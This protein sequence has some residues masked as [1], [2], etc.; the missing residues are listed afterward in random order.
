MK[1]DGRLAPFNM[2][3]HIRYVGSEKHMLPA[4][5]GD[6]TEVVLVSRMVGVVILSPG[7][8]SN[9]GGAAPAPWHCLVQFENGFQLKITTKNR[10]DFEMAGHERLATM[11]AARDY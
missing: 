4:G 7:A 6:E 8:L 9:Q 2:G 1:Q 11:S 10:A 5:Q 3:E